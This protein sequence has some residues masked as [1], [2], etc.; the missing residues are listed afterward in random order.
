MHGVEGTRGFDIDGG[1]RSQVQCHPTLLRTSLEWK[2]LHQVIVQSQIEWNC[3][4]PL[5]L[6]GANVGHGQ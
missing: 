2:S 3:S 6:M 4:E 1:C 5:N